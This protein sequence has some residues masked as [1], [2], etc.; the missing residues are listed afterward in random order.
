M[1][2]LEQAAEEANLITP[3]AFS[4]MIEKRAHETGDPIME[5]IIE[6]CEESGMEPES[7]ARL[8]NRPL[9]ERIECEAMRR[10]L[11]KTRDTT[12]ELEL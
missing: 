8:I 5:L 3:D 12:P 10:N 2:E 1:N 6:Y 9:R 7:A 4:Q 11:F